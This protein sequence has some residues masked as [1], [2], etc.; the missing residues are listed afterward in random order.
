M[1]HIIRDLSVLGSGFFG[2]QND[3]SLLHFV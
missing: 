1:L 2:I 3:A